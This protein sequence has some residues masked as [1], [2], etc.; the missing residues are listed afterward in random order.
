MLKFFNN[1]FLLR[2]TQHWLYAIKSK[3]KIDE[4]KK[5][6]YFFCVSATSTVI[7]ELLMKC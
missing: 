6:T 3:N 7:F 4:E 1:E 2:A 5:L